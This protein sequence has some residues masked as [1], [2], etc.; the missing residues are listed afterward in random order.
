MATYHRGEGGLEVAVKGAPTPVLEACQTIADEDV[1]G[2]RPLSEET[3]RRWINSS[4]NL[5]AEGLRLLA[6]ADKFVDS[7]EEK[8]YEKLRFLG[9][10]GLIDPPRE[11]VRQAIDECQ[12][13]GIRV[14]MVTRRSAR[15][16]G[17][18]RQADGRDRQKGAYG[19][20]RQRTQR[21][22]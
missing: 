17:R 2:S 18:H 6:V 11:N 14:I 3:R 7:T 1:N 13:A 4:E 20:A 12:A 19:Y 8:P 21:P 22:R 16:R 5:A 15:Y 10:V 9:L